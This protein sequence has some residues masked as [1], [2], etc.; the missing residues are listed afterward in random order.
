M[1]VFEYRG[2]VATTGKVV[3]GV[4][5]AENQKALRAALR[6][7]G[8]LLTQATEEKT[9]KAAQPKRDLS[10]KRLFDRPRTRDIAVTTR[11][12]AT[13]VRAKIPL[14]EALTALIEQVE[15]EG[16]RRVLT[17]V[18]DQVREGKSFALALEQHPKVFSPL[19]VNMV[20]A[21][22]ASGTLE[23]VLDRLTGFIEG[24]AR[25]QGK[26]LSALAYPALMMLVATGLI[27]VLMI[28]VVPK[29]TQVFASQKKNLPWY[30]ELLI[31]TSRF[32]A[33]Y[34]WLIFGTL[35]LGIWLF[36]RWLKTTNGRLRWDAM[37]LRSPIFGKLVQMVSIAR[38]SRTLGTLLGSGVPLLQAMDIVR[39]VLGNAALEKVVREAIGS[40][41]EGQGIAAP[42]KK[43]GRFPPLVTHMI[44][45]GERSGQLEEML[46]NVAVA[47]DHEVDTRVQ[48][49]TSLLEPLIIVVMGA[50]VGF[51]AMSILFPL[52]Q[53]SD[54]K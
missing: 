7:D 22:E 27:S 17:D 34:W 33:S 2:I 32:L 9:G 36:R 18:R 47:Y 40:I 42:L 4:R 8:V 5:D 29:L 26:V 30:T 39:T 3:S 24:Q 1:A 14:F 41:R 20:R 53:A 54:F 45:I 52:V 16:L 13:L 23:Q 28:A 10:L 11:Q 19:Y 48:M 38:F 21:G 50:A 46:E 12:L 49:L 25:L 37:S 31:G 51:I 35:G 44:A 43:S 15:R 6:R